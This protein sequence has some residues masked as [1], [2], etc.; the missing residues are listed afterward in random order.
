[1]QLVQT[2]LDRHVP[3]RDGQDRHAPQHMHR[4]IVAAPAARVA[5]ALQQGVVG[6]RF[7]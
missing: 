4:V 2:G 6:Q 1:M 3:Q 5:Q 7:Q